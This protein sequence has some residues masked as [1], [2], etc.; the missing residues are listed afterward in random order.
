MNE[1]DDEPLPKKVCGLTTL[2]LKMN[3]LGTE[4]VKEFSKTIVCDEH[5]KAIDLSD[6]NIQTSSTRRLIDCLNDNN[7]LVNLDISGNPCD[8]P[9][10]RS[11]IAIKLIK[12]YHGDIL[13]GQ[14]EVK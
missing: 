8:C 14:P 4:F 7:S 9:K 10:L 11:I 3:Q 1:E 2:V 12:N 5:I 13:R 6:N